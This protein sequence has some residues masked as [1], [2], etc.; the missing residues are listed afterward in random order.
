MVS[1]SQ[2][3]LS[4]TQLHLLRVYLMEINMMPL[5]ETI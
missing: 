3:F 1:K 2:D 5:H 4:L